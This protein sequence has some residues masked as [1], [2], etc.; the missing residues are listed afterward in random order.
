MTEVVLSAPT[1]A[2]LRRGFSSSATTGEVTAAVATLLV[3]VSGALF[4]TMR[5]QWA[6][7]SGRM[8]VGRRLAHWTWREHDFQGSSSIALE[9]TVDSDGDNRDKLVVVDSSA[10]RVLSTALH[11]PHE[12]LALDEWI[13]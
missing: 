7:R 4:A 13:A 8:S 11:D 10:R 9:H 2:S 6:L 1:P 3:A 5:R 12:L